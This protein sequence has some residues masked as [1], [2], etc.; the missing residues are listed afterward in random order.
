[1]SRAIFEAPTTFPREFR[2]G[3]MVSEMSTKAPVLA[4]PDRLEVLD[5]FAAIDLLK[6]E[7]LFVQ[8]VDGDDDR[9]R[10]ADRLF[11]REAKEPLRAG[12]PAENY[13]VEILR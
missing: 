8:A 4:L 13:A 2:I 7:R 5:A 1:M 6:D 12:V 11:G 10:F 9:Y 3:E